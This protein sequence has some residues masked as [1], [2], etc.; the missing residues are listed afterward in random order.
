MIA[1]INGKVVQKNDESIIIDTQGICYEVLIPSIIMSRLDGFIQDGNIKLITYHYLHSEPSRSIP[2]LI[3]FLNEIEKEFFELF[4]TVSG[5][6]PRA[7]IRAI[8]LPIST[9][10]K[11]INDG[12]TS[13]LCSLPGIGKQRAKEVIAKLQGKMGKFGL[14]K[15]AKAEIKTQVREDIKKEALEVLFKL[16]YK[17]QEAKEMIEKAI[18]RCADIKSTE[19]LLNEVYRQKVK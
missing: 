2:M 10:A 6:G 4:I 3:G 11:G 19:E 7:A 15:D 14:I 12:D 18:N 16:Q 5:I 1:Q 13:L 9:L 17:K 8:K